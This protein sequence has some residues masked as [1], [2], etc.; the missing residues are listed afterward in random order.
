MAKKTG[1]KPSEAWL[2]V[3]SNWQPKSNPRGGGKSERWLGTCYTCA[4]ANKTGKVINCQ[5]LNISSTSS[6]FPHQHRI[7][8]NAPHFKQCPYWQSHTPG[9]TVA[10]LPAPKPL[11]MEDARE[12]D[13]ARFPIA[14][15]SPIKKPS[16]I[17]VG[18]KVVFIQRGALGWEAT[19]T[20]GD[21]TPGK[22]YVVYKIVDSP[23]SIW[24]TDI[25]TEKLVGINFA[26]QHFS[27]LTEQM[28]S[29]KPLP[30]FPAHRHS[31]KK[32]PECGNY[33]CPICG[34]HE[35]MANCVKCGWEG[36]P[37]EEREI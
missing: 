11:T 12:L 16:E 18:D 21:L 28:L 35:L 17:A 20:T 24:V 22:I 4:L 2:N 31:Y 32:K 19:D 26:L 7:P 30:T 37:G 10:G 13:P 29:T 9:Q 23:T 5:K 8:R 33:V 14:K 36:I 6:G 27:K 15:A 1:D 34:T 3:M 25:A